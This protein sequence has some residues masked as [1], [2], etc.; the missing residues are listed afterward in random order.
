MVWYI[1]CIFI[2]LLCP[3]VV[4]DIVNCGKQ[5]LTEVHL[6]FLKRFYYWFGTKEQIGY[7]IGIEEKFV[8]P[9]REVMVLGKC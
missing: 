4:V 8:H 7:S 3:S 1:I 5:R 9:D 2:M 6:G